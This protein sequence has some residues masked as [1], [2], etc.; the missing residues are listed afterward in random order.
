MVSKKNKVLILDAIII[1]IQLFDIAVHLLT[2][3]VEPIRII[4][5]VIIIILVLSKVFSSIPLNQTLGYVAVVIYIILNTVFIVQESAWTQN[6]DFR[7]VFFL[8][9]ISTSLLSIQF[10]RRAS[11]S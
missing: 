7:I 11:K 8:L 4:S 2:N 5:S 6:G 1:F 10:V 9:V 3:Q